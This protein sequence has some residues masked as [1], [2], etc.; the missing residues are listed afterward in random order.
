MEF[1][2]LGP[3]EAWGQSGEVALGG[4]R[5]RALLARLLLSANQVVS[6]DVLI[7]DLWGSESRDSAGN[8]LRVSVARLRKALAAGQ[9]DAA[10]D[11]VL[12]RAP[13]YLIKLRPKQLDLQQFETLLA[14]GSELLANGQ[15]RSASERLR[16]AVELWRGEPLGE[17]AYEDFA[18]AA[19]ARLS[20][21]RLVALERRVEADLAT[22]ESATLVAELE[23]LVR[24]QPLRERLRAHLMLALYRA[25]RQA[26]ALAAYQDARRSLT[27]ELGIEPGASLQ[28]LQVRIL[29]RD[30]DLAAEPEARAPATGPGQDAA[31]PLAPSS[32]VVPVAA[33]REHDLGNVVALGER[34]SKAPGRE[35]MVASAVADAG[36]LA[37]TSAS[38]N[39]LRQ[40]L[41]ARGVTTRTA[42]FT[43]ETPGRIS[44]GWQ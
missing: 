29:Q 11:L 21:L 14:E 19:I 38:L 43:S 17:F 31:S 15:A 26:E 7:D 35:L 5:P 13:G 22:G 44:H 20:E 8:T 27:E 4:P 30:G 6:A 40:S 23:E 34:L 32:R 33:L 39:E 37:A 41:E 18:A 24:E 3:L 16:R 12:T 2:I 10:A 25:G 9:A 42:A 28:Q 1:K 36:E